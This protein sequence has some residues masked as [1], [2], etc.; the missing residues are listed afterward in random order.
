MKGE[1]RREQGV[2]SSSSDFN[3]VEGIGNME[4]TDRC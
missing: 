1:M 2:R 4:G 3:L